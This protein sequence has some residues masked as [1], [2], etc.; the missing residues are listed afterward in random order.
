MGR[1]YYL[2]GAVIASS[3]AVSC[4]AGPEEQSSTDRVNT[5]SDTLL[6]TGNGPFVNAT[7]L[8]GNLSAAGRIDKTNEFFQS[9]GTNGRACVT[10]HAPEDGFSI[11]PK[12]AQQLFDRC[13]AE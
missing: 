6:G 2:L 10:C 11:T 4:G 1:I 8:S 5:S 13:E 3:A 12:H 9:L 7:G